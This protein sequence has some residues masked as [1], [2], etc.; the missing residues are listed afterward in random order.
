MVVLARDWRF[1]S[2][3]AHRSKHFSKEN[4]IGKGSGNG[5]FPL[6]ESIENRGFSKRIRRLAEASEMSS[7]AHI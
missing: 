2:S 3:F 5:S 4:E 6:E 1:E 7:F